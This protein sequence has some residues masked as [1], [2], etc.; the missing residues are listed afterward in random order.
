MADRSSLSF[1]AIRDVL[2]IVAQGVA[3]DLLAGEKKAGAGLELET[4]KSDS[5]GV[6]EANEKSQ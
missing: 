3:R 4:G 1:D 5:C 6:T 2:D